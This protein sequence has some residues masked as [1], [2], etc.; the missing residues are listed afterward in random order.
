MDYWKSQQ[1][2]PSI[3]MAAFPELD[4]RSR[5]VETPHPTT[6]LTALREYHRNG[7]KYLGQEY[8][9]IPRNLGPLPDLEVLKQAL[10]RAEACEDPWYPLRID[11]DSLLSS[12]TSTL[13]KQEL[14]AWIEPIQE[15]L[16]EQSQGKEYLLQKEFI[17]LT[18][19]DVRYRDSL[20]RDLSDVRYSGFLEV[21][22]LPVGHPEAQPF[23][24]ELRFSE[25][26]PGLFRSFLD[27]Q[28]R[29][30]CETYRV[31]PWTPPESTF[32]VL[33]RGQAVAQV[34]GYLVRQLSATQLYS[35]ASGLQ[36]GHQLWDLK[37]QGDA[38]TLHALPLLYDSP[39]TSL[40]DA[41]GIILKHRVLVNE[42]RVENVLTNQ[43]TAHWLGLPLTGLN[44][45]ISVSPGTVDL[46]SLAGETVLE[47]H[48]LRTAEVDDATGLFHAEV[49]LA[50]WHQNGQKT[51]VFGF[52][53]RGNLRDALSK[54]RFSND[55][56]SW[57]TYEGPEFILVPSKAV[58]GGR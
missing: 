27:E 7:R 35:G 13:S 29:L 48:R 11:Q 41:Q 55:I 54:A 46:R 23:H 49:E 32:P 4:N 51:P 33:I 12:K 26:S 47:I 38:L 56:G 58:M 18:K 2:Q 15:L 36:I 25:F 34:F 52:E 9:E 40:F 1:I 20:G 28:G 31:Q 53:L 44:R 6:H 45:N 21:F 14:P 57:E 8:L 19:E 17:R 39:E 43:Q 30:A 22:L 3:V 24:G 42:G 5:V 37:P 50:D 10:V 16:H